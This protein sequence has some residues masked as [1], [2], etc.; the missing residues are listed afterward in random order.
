MAFQLDFLSSYDD[1]SLLAELRRVAA[2]LPNQ[3]ITRTA[4]DAHAKIS[5]SAIGKRFGGWGTALERAGLSDRFE[6][7]Y[8]RKSA[9]TIRTTK[10]NYIAAVQA[11]AK[12]LGQ[13]HITRQ[14]FS[15]HTGS[16]STNYIK[17]FGSW[18]H[19][20]KQA[21]LEQAPLGRRYNDEECF[22]N[23]LAVWTEYGRAPQHD[24]MN[25]SPSKVGSKAY[26]RRWGTWR[27]AL[28]AFVERVNQPGDMVVANPAPIE[29]QET[30]RTKNSSLRGPRNI[31]LGLRYFIL[32]RDSF[33]CTVC[34][35]SPATVHDLV[36]H[37]D[38]IVPWAKGG[39]TIA[40][41]LR[42]LCAHCNLGKGDSLES[43][44]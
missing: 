6:A 1:E 19:L 31:P 2:L 5:A 9:S 35:R 7:S 41:N 39:A 37:I 20:L 14:E 30:E 3:K 16:R 36:L 23:L 42:T 17:L 33:R 18:K 4:F 32:K 15:A 24:E 22:E 12:Q 27:K 11:L 44:I 43:E 38:H 13:T 10:E 28:A 29:E 34:G 25:E 26:V 21:G 8:L 40:T